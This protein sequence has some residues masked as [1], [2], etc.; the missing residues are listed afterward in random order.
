MEH[1]PAIGRLTEADRLSL[2][3]IRSRTAIREIAAEVEAQCGV[4][5]SDIFS[6][7]RAPE[8]V[9]AR[10]VVCVIA[11]REGWSLNQIARAIGRDHSSV[12]AAIE[13]EHARRSFQEGSNA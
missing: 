4:P 6:G 1:H 11:R 13:R 12:A 7:S 2:R 10:D 5:Q 3:G 8:H 9:H